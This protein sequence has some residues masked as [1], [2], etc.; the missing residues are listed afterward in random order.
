[1]PAKELLEGSPFPRDE[2]TVLGDCEG[3]STSPPTLTPDFR[4]EKK[5]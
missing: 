1:M 2:R 5:Q 4:Q 3:R